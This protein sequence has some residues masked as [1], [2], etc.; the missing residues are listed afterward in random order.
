MIENNG[1]DFM[2]GFY[3]GRAEGEIVMQ[4]RILK[5]IKENTSEYGSKEGGLYVKRDHF[6]SDDLIAF[7]EENRNPHARAETVVSEIVLEQKEQ[8]SACSCGCKKED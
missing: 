4:E 5:W 8:E 6:D 1:S 2:Q 7:I 3:R